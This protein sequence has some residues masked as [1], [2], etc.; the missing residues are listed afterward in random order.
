MFAKQSSPI[1]NPR[2][3]DGSNVGARYA[4][5]RRCVRD[6]VHDRARTARRDD[7]WTGSPPNQG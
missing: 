2:T 3:S 7:S 1:I 5:K 4:N 6:G